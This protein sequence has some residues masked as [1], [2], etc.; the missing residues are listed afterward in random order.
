MEGFKTSDHAQVLAC[1]T[2]DVVWD[3]PGVF[4]LV[5]K[6][7]FDHEIEN[8][9]FVGRPAIEVTRMI[10]SDDIVVAEGTVVAGRR[11][12][13]TLNAVFCDLFEME[14]GKIRRLVSYVMEVK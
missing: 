3:M 5:G 11:D 13:G 4:H 7:A 6:V 12:G 10:E 9:A 2:D 1:L 14:G 8:P